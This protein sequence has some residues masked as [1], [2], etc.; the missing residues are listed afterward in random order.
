MMRITTTRAAITIVFTAIA[1]VGG[2]LG[3]ALLGRA[4]VLW[5]AEKKLND[6]ALRVRSEGETASEESRALLAA[7]NQ[8]P[9][10]YCSE[11]EIRWMRR[12][13]FQSQYLKDGGHMRAGA[14][15]CSA[16]LGRMSGTRE[17]FKPAFS[18][19]DGT[20]VYQDLPPLRIGDHTV[21]S[22]ELGKSFIVYSP[23]NLKD[24]DAAPMH[25][26]VS[27][28]DRQSGQAR[29]LLGELTDARSSILT[30]EGWARWGDTLYATR[31][32]TRY[33]SCMT[34]FITIP[35]ALR[36]GRGD[37][38]AYIGL[39]GVSGALFG[40]ACSLLYRRSRGMEQQLR[41]A[42]RS[43]RLRVVYQPIVQMDTGQ[44]MGAEALVRW[45]DE[46]DNPVSPEL[47][48]RLAEDR[49]FVGEITLLVARHIVS[50]CGALF[51]SRPGFRVNL[52]I[53][54]ADLSDEKFLPRL[55]QALGSGGVGAAS[56]GIE[57]TEG[58]TARLQVA[59]EAII[60]LRARGHL[61]YIDDFGTGYSS[62]AYLQDLSVDGIKID[63]AFTQAIG[64]ESVTVSILPQILAMARALKLDVIVEGVETREQAAYFAGSQQ[65]TLAQGWLFGKPAPVG[66]LERLL[67]EQCE[68]SAVGAKAS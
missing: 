19:Q 14:I 8:S 9:Y 45:N 37:Y 17:Q 33:S 38:W 65:T 44:I 50:E 56:L 31:C 21:V 55:E 16:T 60:E 47:L 62:L 57:I 61:V 23:Y 63:M 15:D 4:L 1:A 18:R 13:I 2:L 42:I 5:R 49:G 59:K 41:R 6:Y 51:R 43:D 58:H 46:E 39:M 48:I 66:E 68:L 12:L 30:K 35:D 22:V 34:A 32:S 7:M 25:F 54:A 36:S 10:P 40:L 67:A 24:L 52:N 27:Q 29:R 64:T 20:R 53:A 3:G 11:A 26:T 28:V